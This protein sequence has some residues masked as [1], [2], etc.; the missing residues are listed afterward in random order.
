LIRNGPVTPPAALAGKSGTAHGRVLAKPG[1]RDR[2]DHPK[3]C[4]AIASLEG[5][6]V[7]RPHVIV[8]ASLFVALA[9]APA[10]RADVV[11][12][13]N[14]AALEAIR[15][16]RTP[17]P[18]A[19]RALAILHASIYDAVNGIA[20][21]HEPYFVRSGGPRDASTRAAANA[22]GH[23][24]L[25]GL[26]PTRA[27]DFDALRDA[28]LATIADNRGR[29][30]GV[31]W[32]ESV[33]RQILTW[34]ASDNSTAAVAA[35]AGVGPGAWVPTPPALTPYV[36]PHWGAVVPF[37]MPTSSHFRPSGPP[38]LDSATY[39]AD[40][41]EVKSLGAALGSS[42]TADQTTIALFWADG[43]GTETPPGHW[44]T[45]ARGV[46]ATRDPADSRRHG[47]SS[48]DDDDGEGGH[49]SRSGTTLADNARLFALLN[50]AMADAAICA[51]EAKYRYNFWRPVTAVRGADDDG[52]P[53]TAAD[54]TWSSLLATP[55]F[56][57]Y[58][59]GHSAFSGAAATVL[60]R[61]FGSDR[62]AFTTGSDFLPVVTRSF[63][64]FSD[65]AREAAESRL[66][67]GIHFRS[68]NADGF[69]A[70]IE[71][72]AWASRRFLR[73]GAHR[74]RN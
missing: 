16:L 36:L 12:D 58:V 68:A 38:A 44:N 13:W 57:D 50:L 41:N 8:P 21:T 19:A 40:L 9:F 32:G 30:D 46:A 66:Y 49:G 20:Q 63:A 45:I 34:R 56:P 52:N 26:F 25:T 29:R 6:I 27:G 42:R 1:R 7:K 51:W 73:P 54:P 33:A 60:A 35:P 3:Q 18:V 53:H 47:R 2:L 55:P 17:P 61:F 67:G 72:G 24:A 23:T 37:T 14:V 69:A 71:I 59:S 74:S 31:A 43:A 11:T 28:T 65:A 5:K 48:D 4:R 39:A 15:T 70:G 22:A 62:I 64:R 10:A